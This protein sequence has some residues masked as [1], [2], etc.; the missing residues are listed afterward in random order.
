[1]WGLMND[2][3]L[4]AWLAGAGHAM[5]FHYRTT[6]SNGQPMRLIL[7]YNGLELAR[8]KPNTNPTVWDKT[9][10]SK[11]RIH[12]SDDLDDIAVSP[13]KHFQYEIGIRDV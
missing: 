3:Q 9:V 11:L 2:A 4:Q 12:F 10:T 1:M 13:A 5:I 7:S 6:D 8:S